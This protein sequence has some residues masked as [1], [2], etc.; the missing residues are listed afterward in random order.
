MSNGCQRGVVLVR[1]REDVFVDAC[2]LDIRLWGV[3]DNEAVNNAFRD[4]VGDRMPEETLDLD[5]RRVWGVCRDLGRVIVKHVCERRLV[6]SVGGSGRSTG[7]V[8][9]PSVDLSFQ[10]R[11]S[12]LRKHHSSLHCDL[13][14]HLSREMER[15]LMEKS[16]IE[17]PPSLLTPRWLFCPEPS[18]SAMRARRSATCFS[19]S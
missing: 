6:E 17:F 1:T 2:Q 5:T 9:G 18:R 19:C 16:S 11:S 13:L 15:T 8:R 4:G 10:P 7:N 14:Q 12:V 3:G